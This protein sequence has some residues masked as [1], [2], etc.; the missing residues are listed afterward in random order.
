MWNK[1]ER[2]L[3]AERLSCLSANKH[4]QKYSWAD[5][6][7]ANQQLEHNDMTSDG[8]MHTFQVF[9]YCWMYEPTEFKM[10]MIYDWQTALPILWNSCE[11]FHAVTNEIKFFR[12]RDLQS[13]AGPAIQHWRRERSLFHTHKQGLTHCVPWNNLLIQNSNLHSQSLG[14]MF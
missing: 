9:Q 7:L 1:T 12:F 2:M 14:S 4:V 6:L 11:M 8:R 10:K 13:M 3:T 5:I